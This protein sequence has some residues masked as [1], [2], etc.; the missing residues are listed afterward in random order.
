M[1]VNF[2]DPS[3]RA[4]VTSMLAK[5]QRVSYV[6]LLCLAI[7]TLNHGVIIVFDDDIC[8]EI[9]IKLFCIQPSGSLKKIIS[10]TL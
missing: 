6:K 1:C 8:F 2:Q 9:R 4:W 3:S 7:P 10:N 5:E